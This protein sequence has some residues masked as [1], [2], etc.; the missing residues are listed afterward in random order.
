LESEGHVLLAV[1]DP[2]NF[3][4]SSPDQWK[5][6]VQAALNKP[7]PLVALAPVDKGGY[8]T[9]Y[10][11]PAS[12]DAMKALLRDPSVQKAVMTK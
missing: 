4:G 11:L 9:T 10:D 6:W 7:L 1:D 5:A 12:V 8:V 3:S 2:G